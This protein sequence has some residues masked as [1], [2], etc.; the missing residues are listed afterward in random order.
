MSKITQYFIPL[1][2]ISGWWYMAFFGEGNSTPP[3]NHSR[4]TPPKALTVPYFMSY[5]SPMQRNQIQTALSGNV[6]MMTRLMK[7]WD[8]DAQ[9][10]ESQGLIGI[11]KLKRSSFIRAQIIGRKLKDQDFDAL[12][13]LKK[14]VASVSIFDDRGLQ[15][16]SPSQFRRFLP[17]TFVA[18]SFLFALTHPTQIVA[19]PH[20]LR[21]QT[22][23]YPLSLTSQ[24]PLDT[25]RIF[26][27]K[28]YQTHP[29]IAFVADYS[30][31][32]TLETLANQGIP[33][34]TL[35]SMNTINHVEQAIQRIGNVVDRPLEAEVLSLF[36]ESALIAID[37]R[38]IATHHDLAKDQE[39]PKVMFLNYYTRYS[40]PTDRTIA[41]DLLHR[42]N[43]LHVSLVP[44]LELY[45]DAWSHPI[46][47]EQIICANPDCLIIA[48]NDLAGLQQ[49]IQ[50]NPA[51]ANVS[52]HLHNQIH[53]VDSSTQA[54][55]QYI[56]LAYYDIAQALMKL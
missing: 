37:N 46:D 14:Q 1:L 56:I 29:D 26:S 31:P 32:A 38:L 40:I 47:Q 3:Q 16:K 6:E 18:A 45:S 33:F 27:E 44:K 54:P 42:L 9:I 55:T 4:Y 30:H 21:D 15:F 41:G 52:A 12:Q 13:L 5:L 35:K 8:V 7:E 39:A 36:M 48:T 19:I 17:Q 28:L 22:D 2:F 43:H 25:D 51:F 23:L 34:F 20:G 50:A 11:R 49:S 10:L 24:I 53:I